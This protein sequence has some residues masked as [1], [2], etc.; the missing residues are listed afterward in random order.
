MTEYR[1]NKKDFWWDF[2]YLACYDILVLICAC[3]GYIIVS[4]N[5][6]GIEEV[7]FFVLFLVATFIMAY[8]T[9]L[10]IHYYNQNKDAIVCIDF[11]KKA[12][13]SQYP[14]KKIQIAIPF[15]RIRMIRILPNFRVS[16][17]YLSIKTADNKQWVYLF[18]S[19]LFVD[20]AK[21]EYDFP[22]EIKKTWV[23]TKMKNNFHQFKE[24]ITHI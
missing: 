18:F 17:C 9:Y 3:L 11:D 15:N 10:W 4:I 8:I 19:E 16:F 20:V 13:I 23:G 21:Y 24:Y 22:F 7:I 14:R 6:Y 12:I 5:G 1:F 2:V